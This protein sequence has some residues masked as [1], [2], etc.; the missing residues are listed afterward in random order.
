M[1]YSQYFDTICMNIVGPVHFFVLE[2]AKHM[3]KFCKKN[4][5][6]SKINLKEKIEIKNK[7]KTDSFV[8]SHDVGKI[9]LKIVSSFGASK[10]DE[11][12]TWLL[13]FSVYSMVGIF[14]YCTFFE[15]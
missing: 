8:V 6:L 9:P 3:L 10:S 12:K 5:Y 2:S 11:Y 15:Q 13:L 4:G 7:G 14:R 1:T